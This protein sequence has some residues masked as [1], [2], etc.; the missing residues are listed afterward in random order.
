[1]FLE[2]IAENFPNLG[3]A[4]DIKIQETQKTI[5][6]NNSRP[7]PRPIGIEFAKYTDQEN[8]LKTGKQVSNFQGKPLKASRNFFSRNFA[9]QKGVV[10]SIQRGEWEKSVAK[11]TL[12]IKPITQNRR[13][14]VSQIKN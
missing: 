9:S 4:K 14:R 2:I 1:M 5:K 13:D 3:K 7:T 11:N 8:I 6:I 10:L 12:S